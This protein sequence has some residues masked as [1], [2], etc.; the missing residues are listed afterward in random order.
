MADMNVDDNQ[1]LSTSNH[2]YTPI[3][4]NRLTSPTKKHKVDGLANNEATS[5]YF[6]AYIFNTSTVHGFKQL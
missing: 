3:K 5:N 1:D 4:L 2:D 6:D